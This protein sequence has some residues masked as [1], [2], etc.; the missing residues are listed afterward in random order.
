MSLRQFGRSVTVRRSTRLP[1]DSETETS[2]TS[3]TSH[4][5]ESS[6]DDDQDPQQS[7]SDDDEVAEDV[8]ITEGGWICRVARFEKHVDSRGRVHHVKDSRRK[9]SSAPVAN[10]DVT[11]GQKPAKSDGDETKNRVKQSIIRF[12]R[13]ATKTNSKKLIHPEMYIEI[14][15]PLILEVLRR[16]MSYEKEV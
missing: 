9:E 2:Q 6:K 4:S 15:S 1:V 12:F 8:E 5:S 14:K 10:Q 3:Q 7:V 13:H 16:N 11:D